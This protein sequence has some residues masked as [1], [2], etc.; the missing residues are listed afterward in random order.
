MGPSG[1]ALICLSVACLI[2]TLLVAILAGSIPFLWYRIQKQDAQ[3]EALDSVLNGAV[4]KLK[5][6]E[7]LILKR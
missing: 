4:E 7:Q 5:E 6:H 1:I 2:L 3:L